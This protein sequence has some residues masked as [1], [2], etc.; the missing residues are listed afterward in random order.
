MYAE[1]VSEGWRAR[2]IAG[3][4]SSHAA[5][6]LGY[7]LAKSG[8]EAEARFILEGLSK[9]SAERHVSPYNMAPLQRLRRA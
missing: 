2:E 6:F 4:R 3:A 8:K 1:A 9:S 7:A 5:A